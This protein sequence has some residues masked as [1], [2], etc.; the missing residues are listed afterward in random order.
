MKY[1][2]HTKITGNN[3]TNTHVSTTENQQLLN[4]SI[5]LEIFKEK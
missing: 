2:K 4:L 5:L 1:F 3:K